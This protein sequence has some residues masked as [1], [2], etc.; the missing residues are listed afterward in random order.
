MDTRKVTF[1]ATIAAIILVAVGIGYAYTAMTT[2]SSNTAS[3]EYITLYQGGDGSYQFAN[4]AQHIYWDTIDGWDGNSSYTTTYK[5]SEKVFDLDAGNP[6]DILDN[7]TLVQV[8]SVFKIV[9]DLQIA[10][11]TTYGQIPASLTGTIDAKKFVGPLKPTGTSS[12]AAVFIVIQSEDNTKA[13]ELYKVVYK[14]EAQTGE[15]IIQKYDS[16]SGKFVGANT[17][18]IYRVGETV[19]YNPASVTVLYGYEGTAGVIATH[20]KGSAPAAADQPSSNPL[21]EASL[22]FKLFKNSANGGVKTVT[23]VELGDESKTVVIGAYETTTVNVT[24]SNTPTTGAADKTVVVS[25][26]DPTK[27]VGTI[28]AEGTLTI[29]GLSKTATNPAAPVTITVTSIID[30]SKSDSISVTVNES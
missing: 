2:N 1:I 14:S 4:G 22:S 9:P 25:S 28:T 29:Y 30:G 15:N 21:D 8:G 5:L 16:T 11:G 18:T 23:A 26:S 6:S 17:F 10:A 24:V 12:E 3:P 7:Y 20:A 27:A 19:A 13:P